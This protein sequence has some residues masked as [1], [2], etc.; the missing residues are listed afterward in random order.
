MSTKRNWR[1]GSELEGEQYTAV[2]D[3]QDVQAVCES[4]GLSADDTENITAAMVIIGDGE[5]VKIWLSESNRP[6]DLTAVYRVAA[7]YTETT[8]FDTDNVAFKDANTLI[9][10]IKK[11]HSGP[12]ANLAAYLR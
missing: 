4:V 11:I 7:W 1:Y 10:G 2:W 3:S 12:L 8:E 6:Y 9:N 5:Y